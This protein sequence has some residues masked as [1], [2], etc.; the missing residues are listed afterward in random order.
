MSIEIYARVTSPVLST[1]TRLVSLVTCDAL[2][3]LAG[4]APADVLEAV[5]KRRGETYEALLSGTRVHT[6]IE[7][8][9]GWMVDMSRA[10]APIA[11]PAFLPMA[12]VLAE[13]VTLEVGARGIRGLFSSKPSEK[14]LQHVRTVGVL[15]ARFLRTVFASDGSLDYE[16]RRTVAQFVSALGLPEAEARD[17]YGEAAIPTIDLDVPKDLDPAIARAMVRG[18]W[19]A[20]GW[21]TMEAREENTIRAMAKKLLVQAADVEAMRAEAIARHDATRALGA[22]SIEA[23]RYMLDDR[24]PEVGATLAQYVGTLMLPRRY[25]DMSL[26]NLEHWRKVELGGRHRGL[27]GDEKNRV[28][29]IAWLLALQE[30]PALTRRSM[31]RSKH[32]RLAQDLGYDG[33]RPRAQLD[34]WLADVLAPATFP[35]T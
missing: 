17:L 32:D 20:S 28:L 9:D 12:E 34:A 21:D 35:L 14:E 26:G 2:Y 33:A 22:A 23:A 6:M 19:L 4:G 7:S 11:P 27:T 5:S 15:T 16:E 13:K 3:V 8:F 25:R 29:E 31:L 18:A 30:D 1:L 24:I 10:V